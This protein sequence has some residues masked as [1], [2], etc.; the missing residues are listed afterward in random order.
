MM[1][2]TR[3]LK[4]MDMNGKMVLTLFLLLSTTLGFIATSRTSLVASETPEGNQTVRRVPEEYEAIQGAIDAADVGDIIWVAAGQ[5]HEHI[6]VDKSV[7]LLGEEGT[8]IDGDATG[9]VISVTGN[10]VEISG[11]TIQ[12]GYR[13]ILLSHSINSTIRNN[14]LI[15]HTGAAIE[16]QYSNETTISGNRVSNSDHAIYLLYTSCRNTMSNNVIVNNSQGLPLSWYC[17]GNIIVG[18]TVTSNSFAG[19]V[20]GGSNNNTIYHNNFIDNPD[21]VYSYNSLNV[22][23]NGAEGN[24]WSD[25][26]GKDLDGNGIGDTRLPHKKLDYHPLMEPWSTT[27]VFNIAWGVETFQVTTVCNSTVASFRFSL[28]EEQITFNVTS[29]EIGFC[30]VTIPKRLLWADPRRAW[31]TQV[32]GMRAASTIAENATHTSLYF[33]YTHSTHMVKIT[34]TAVIQDTSPPV[35]NA[36]P[37]QTVTE[38]EPLFFDANDCSDNLGIVDYQWDFGDGTMGTGII[39]TYTYFDPG[40]YVVTLTVGDEAGNNA[41]DSATITVLVRDTDDDGIPDAT[42]PDDDNDGMADVW[43]T[44]NGLN[45][46]DAAD[47]SLNPDKDGLTNLQEYQR[48]TNPDCPDSDGDFWNDSLDLMPGN[49]VFPN[50]AMI[51]IGIILLTIMVRKRPT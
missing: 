30:N 42:D 27:R 47:A 19:I 34:G 43:E 14:I 16:L 48:G 22:W 8:I 4:L 35:A 24:Y 7:T 29:G 26:R 10:H 25:Y 32:D 5:Y 3:P 2:Y 36:G 18:N 44:E 1:T 28:E 13:G 45:P 33:T 40:T 17:D 39:S 31:L 23:D 51:V 46:I 15:S 41:T 6:S 11:F 38:D 21:Q 49:A 9:N 20:L 37:D 50:G 12:D